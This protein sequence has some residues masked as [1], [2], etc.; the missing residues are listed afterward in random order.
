MRKFSLLFA[1]AVMAFTLQAARAEDTP[2]TDDDLIVDA[3]EMDTVTFHRRGGR[4]GWHEGPRHM[5]RGGSRRGMSGRGFGGP[6]FG[7]D[8]GPRDGMPGMGMMHRGGM[9]HGGMRHDMFGPRFMDELD[10]T[11]EQKTALIDVVSD[12]FK[13]RM[14]AKM[15]LHDAIAALRNLRESDNPDHDALIAANAAVGTAQGRMDVA[16]RKLKA[17]VRAL[18][19]PEQAQ[20]LDDR[21][22]MMETRREEMRNNRPER[23]MRDDNFRGPGHRGPGPREGGMRRG[24]GHG[25]R[26]MN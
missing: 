15:E 5:D 6:C 10:L 20:K 16:D 21:R 13:A 19:T 3:G 4:G 26:H 14:Q 9:R 17:E 25:P 8:C 1:A 24:G 7:S 11:A 23:G 12:N 2:L 22:E 18:L